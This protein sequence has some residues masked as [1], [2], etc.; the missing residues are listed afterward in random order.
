MEQFP[1]LLSVMGLVEDSGQGL[2]LEEAGAVGGGR[3]ARRW[4]WCR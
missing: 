1:T 2:T 4:S 3:A